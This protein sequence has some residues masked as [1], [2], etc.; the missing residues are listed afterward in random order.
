MG[1]ASAGLPVQGFLRLWVWLFAVTS[2]CSFA[3]S[4]EV[5]QVLGGSWVVGKG[6]EFGV[7]RQCTSFMLFSRNV[8][9]EPRNERGTSVTQD[10]CSLPPLKWSL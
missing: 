1:W 2:D 7:K 5:K 6:H 8:F 10:Y 3:K 4:V 9:C